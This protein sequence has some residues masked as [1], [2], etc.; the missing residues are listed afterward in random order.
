MSNA[1]SKYFTMLLANVNLCY[2]KYK[3]RRNYEN[4][5]ADGKYR[6]RTVVC[7]RAR[8]SMYIETGARKIL[9]DMGAS[10]QFAANAQKAGRGFKQGGHRNPVPR[11]QRSRRRPGRLF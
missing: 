9:F 11:S 3:G 6:M 7:L 1:Y 10:D 8:L 5:D 2:T 4:R